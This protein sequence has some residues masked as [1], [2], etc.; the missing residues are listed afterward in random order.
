LVTDLHKLAT[1]VLD[2]PPDIATFLAHVM[3]GS[4]LGLNKPP[5]DSRIIRMSPLISPV[6]NGS[7]W[8]APG[9]MSAAQFLYLSKLDMDAVEQSQ[10]DAIS[11]YA[12]LWLQGVA[13]NQPLRMNG[14][15]L[16]PELGQTTFP[17]AMA[18]WNAV[19]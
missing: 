2:D 12:D 1:S 14:D 16:D 6:K 19:K 10:V 11:A 15:T 17:A 18:A 8:S 4:G 9:A 13:P 7:G 3:T 5:A